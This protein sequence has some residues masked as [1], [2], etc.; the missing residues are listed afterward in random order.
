M[1]Y[2]RVHIENSKNF[3]TVVTS[4]SRAILIDNIDLLR[5]SFKHVKKKIEFNIDA[6]VV[7]PDHIHMII[8]P[9]DTNTYPEI[10]KQ[11]KVNFSRNDSMKDK[12][13]KSDSLTLYLYQHKKMIKNYINNCH[14]SY[15]ITQ[16]DYLKYILKSLII[17][18]CVKSG[19]KTKFLIL[20]N[21]FFFNLIKNIRLSTVNSINI[22]IALIIFSLSAIDYKKFDSLI[23]YLD[24]IKEET[25]RYTNKSFKFQFIALFIH[26]YIKASDYENAYKYC[27]NTIK[28]LD[29]DTELFFFSTLNVIFEKDNEIE[30]HK[31]TKKIIKILSKKKNLC[32]EDYFNISILSMDLKKLTNN[33]DFLKLSIYYFK[34][35][36]KKYSNSEQKGEFLSLISAAYHDLEKYRIAIKYEEFAINKYYKDEQ[37][38]LES[39]ENIA[40]CYYG[41][42]EFEKALTV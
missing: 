8:Q 29:E 18:F 28:F 11:I 4:K 20:L 32:F 42:F 40:N 10:I 37:K 39:K 14:S 17:E 36:F 12:N 19:N 23:N 6:I 31:K 15:A 38:I 2:R 13:S 16:N 9:K 33:K 24:E 22:R 34:K 26:L 21:K 1:N 25:F 5:N 3:I 41:L 27:L 35:S 30:C 7:L